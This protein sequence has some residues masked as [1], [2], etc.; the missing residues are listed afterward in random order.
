MSHRQELSSGASLTPWGEL[1]A[2]Q[3]GGDGETGAGLEVGGGARY[4]SSGSAWT[5]EGYGRRLVTHEGTLREWGLGAVIRFSP[6]ASGLG[7]VVSLQPS[8]GDTVSG[9][10]R[11]WEHSASDLS[12]P[13]GSGTRVDAQFGY[14]L[15][16][17]GRG[18]LTPFGAVR[19]DEDA[20]RDYR[21][22]W[23]LAMSR[24]ATVSLEAERS[25]RIAGRV[26]HA[27]LL[28]GAIQF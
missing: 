10:E 11:L 4:R 14:G 16:T 27:V 2:R 12:V 17:R 7:P 25:E 20:G 19:L 18:V 23:R 9:V 22:G 15:P 1:G 13:R 3:D 6:R 24:A 21:L 5:L 8:W 26:V 28:R